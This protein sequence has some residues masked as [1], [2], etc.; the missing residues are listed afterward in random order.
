MHAAI[1]PVA[2]CPISMLIRSRHI[3]Q[4]QH[5]LLCGP[6]RQKQ[7]L[8]ICEHGTLHMLAG[9]QAQQAL[10]DVVWGLE[11]QALPGCA[12][13]LGDLV[14]APPG[15]RQLIGG[16]HLMGVCAAASAA[17]TLAVLCV[18]VYVSCWLLGQTDYGLNATGHQLAAPDM[19]R[20]L[21]YTPER[22]IGRQAHPQ[23]GWLVM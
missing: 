4:A 12:A 18:C 2:Q 23:A 7:R 19:T 6:Y 9:L 8:L 22:T 1:Q 14:G 15:N 11:E 20:A 10:L 17:L 16:R 13:S 21:L 5:G 3:A